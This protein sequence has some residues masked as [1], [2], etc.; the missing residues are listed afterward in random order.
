MYLLRGKIYEAYVSEI[1]ACMKES[2][3]T[4][5]RARHFAKVRNANKEIRNEHSEV[6]A[7]LPTHNESLV[8][9]LPPRYHRTREV[10]LA[11]GSNIISLEDCLPR[12]LSDRSPDSRLYPFNNGE[13]GLASEIFP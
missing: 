11:L 1:C 10:Y 4:S 8:I 2:L 12:V 13:M 7:Y 3:T 9:D 5:E 6:T